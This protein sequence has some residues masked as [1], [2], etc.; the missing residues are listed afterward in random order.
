MTERSRFILLVIIALLSVG[1][2]V[3]ARLLIGRAFINQ[4]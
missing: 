3:A 4:L 2:L 1:L